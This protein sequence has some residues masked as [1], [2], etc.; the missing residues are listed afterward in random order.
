MRAWT[1][2]EPWASL[3]VLREKRYET[4]SRPNRKIVGERLA[5]HAAKKFP[6]WALDLCEKEPFITSLAHWDVE[7]DQFA[8]GCVI[9]FATVVTCQPVEEVAHKLSLKELAFGDYH[10]GRYC[11][12][13]KDSEM[14]EPVPAKGALSIWQWDGKGDYPGSDSLAGLKA[15]YARQTPP[16]TRTA[17][18]DLLEMHYPH[19]GPPPL[20][21]TDPVCT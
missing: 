21:M 15:D 1:L 18:F 5:I 7:P 20:K 17:A 13:F 19:L 4:R 11:F 16:H 6:Q 12:L 10:P 3:V 14:I 9:G 8:L 2:T